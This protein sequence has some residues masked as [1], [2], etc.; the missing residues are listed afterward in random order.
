MTQG[1][2]A[3]EALREDRHL[4]GRATREDLVEVRRIFC[5]M[6]HIGALVT[7]LG[8]GPAARALYA[9]PSTRAGAAAKALLTLTLSRRARGFDVPYAAKKPLFT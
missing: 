3:L 8:R 5:I 7:C 4:K 2:M 6:N 9:G 1:A